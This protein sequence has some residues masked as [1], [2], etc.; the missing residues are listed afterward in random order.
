MM[1]ETPDPRDVASSLRELPVPSSE[2]VAH[3]TRLVEH[4]RAEIDA[5]GG[6]ISF[7]RFMELALYAPGL[8]YYSA[9][10]HKLGE[11][12]D[13]ITAPELSPLFSRS[14]AHQCVVILKQV[15]GGNILEFGAGSGIMAADILAELE[16]LDFL[17]ERYQILEV[18]A[19]L[20]QRQRQMLE[21]RIPHLVER[22][23]WLTA[24]PAPGFRGVVLANE[25]LDAMPVKRFR[26]V[27]EDIK[28]LEVL[29]EG[30][31]FAEI[32]Q[33]SASAG[34]KDAAVKI[35]DEFQLCDGYESE[36]GL[37]AL[38]WVR[39]LGEM[40][41]KGAALL[42]DYGFPCHEF[43]HPERSGGTLMCHYRHRSHSDPLI[44]VGLQDITAHVDFTAVAEAAVEAGL[45]VAG[46]S[47]QANFLMANGLMEM[48]SAEEDPRRQLAL[49]AQ[50]KRLM[51]PGE[52]GEF[53][54]VMALSRD[55]EDGVGAFTLRDERV[56]L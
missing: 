36:V 10:S 22:V 13:F 6:S 9:G 21:Q 7:E 2:A 46:F 30:D 15:E 5:C 43:Y 47:N 44:L 40:L 12:G 20:Q 39:A 32:A 54:K 26:I 24:M 14:L 51:L 18:S 27:G 42:I 35:R 34:L 1:C 11:K 49:S 55:L 56:R 53:F 52:M 17:P 4:I 41:D 29:W 38:E 37:Q 19:D 25:V 28:E 16:R 33:R 23:E 8:G 48:V 45:H 3:S 31:H 50:V